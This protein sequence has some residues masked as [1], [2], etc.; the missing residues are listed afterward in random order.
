MTSIHKAGWKI[1]AIT[2]LILIVIN[3]LFIYFVQA[4]WLITSILILSVLFLIFVLR[5]FRNPVREVISDDDIVVAPADGTVVVVEETF[6]NEILNTNCVQV[7]IFMSVW[8]VHINWIPISGILRYFKYHKG[9]FL[10]ANNP[11]SST[12]NER[13]TLMIESEDNKKIVVRQI[14]GYV[15]RRIETYTTQPEIEVKKGQQLGFI[16]F[17]SRVDI[18]FPIGAEILV[19][20]GDTTKGCLT[21]IAKL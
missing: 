9:K 12:L 20:I 18:L 17:G 2:T 4:K 5:F 6:D 13:A 14:A 8:N 11:K 7:S 16:K 3:F 15:A 1:T 19:K 21:P 10:I